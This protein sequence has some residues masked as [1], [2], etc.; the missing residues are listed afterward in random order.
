MAH[1]ITIKLQHPAREFAAGESC[2]F[3][4]RGGVRYYDRQA[5]KNEFTNYQA[6]IFAKDKQADFYR[7]ALTAGAIV[8]LTGDNIKVDIYEGQ[9]GQSI[10]LELLNARIGFIE[11]GSGQ[12][13][14]KQAT[15]QSRGQSTGQSEPPMDFDDDIPFASIG[16]PFTTHAIHSI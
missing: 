3:S 8:E 15:Q 10:T 6:V 2:G 12:E 7:D 1:T 5:K 4:V 14:P 9:N 13:K 11:A 16:L